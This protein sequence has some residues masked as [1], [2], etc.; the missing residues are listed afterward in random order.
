MSIG[1][2]SSTGRAQPPNN[3]R[4]GEQPSSRR[5]AAVK[6][7]IFLGV[8]VNPTPRGGNQG[9][10]NKLI[11]S[12]SLQETKPLK[13]LTRPQRIDWRQELPHACAC[14]RTVSARHDNLTTCRGVCARSISGGDG[15]GNECPTDRQ[16]GSMPL[17][18][19]AQQVGHPNEKRITEEEGN[20]SQ[21]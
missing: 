18:K 11:S 21:K 1:I 8:C 4:Q 5:R 3:K 16:C 6:A 2:L 17:K 10:A 19:C 7:Q 15:G 12:T 13:K 9:Y 20:K 14:Q